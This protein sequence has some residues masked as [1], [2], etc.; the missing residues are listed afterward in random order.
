M[1]LAEIIEYNVAA[2]Q[3]VIHIFNSALKIIIDRLKIK[4]SPALSL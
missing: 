3:I 2:R 4:F 1:D